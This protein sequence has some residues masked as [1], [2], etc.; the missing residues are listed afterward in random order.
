MKGKEDEIIPL[1]NVEPQNVIRI[2]NNELIPADSILVSGLASI[3]YSFVTG[4]SVP[5]EKKRGDKLFA[6]GRQKGTAIEVEITK[7][8]EN[9]YLTQLWNNPIFNKK[10]RKRFFI[11]PG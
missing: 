1:Q 4:E 2:R 3:D 10:N 9:S 6:G 8:I 5:V 11:R 7:K